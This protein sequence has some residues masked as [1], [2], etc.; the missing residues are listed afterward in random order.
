MR[1]LNTAIMALI[2]VLCSPVHATPAADVTKVKTGILPS[3]ELYSLY[4]VQCKDQF[5]ASV[6]SL[7]RGRQWCTHQQDQLTCFRRMEQAST[8]ACTQQRQFVA[9]DIPPAL[10]GD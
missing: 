4:D 10:I 8:L 2:L 1:S 3:G 9:N 7:Q 5:R 6:A